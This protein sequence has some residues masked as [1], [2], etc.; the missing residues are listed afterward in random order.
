MAEGVKKLNQP[1]L[2]RRA[3][4][5]LRTF[6]L[7]LKNHFKAFAG[8]EAGVSV[9]ILKALGDGMN[10][11]QVDGANLGDDGDGK[12]QLRLGISPEPTLVGLVGDHG[13]LKGIVFHE[14]PQ[15]QGCQ[16]DQHQDDYD[17]GTATP[18]L[19]GREAPER[20]IGMSMTAV[21]LSDPRAKSR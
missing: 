6:V 17:D 4:R 10:L 13:E 3:E 12:F 14:P 1:V 11:I 7:E 9:G 8:R 19:H 20:L 21:V 2:V 18:L 15:E 16:G 5:E